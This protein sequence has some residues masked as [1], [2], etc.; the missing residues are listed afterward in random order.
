MTSVTVVK[1]DTNQTKPYWPIGDSSAAFVSTGGLSTL[2]LLVSG[3]DLRL[4]LQLLDVRTM[5]E[6]L[7]GAPRASSSRDYERGI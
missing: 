7:H 6:Y 3:L 1:L 2:D 5:P 4:S